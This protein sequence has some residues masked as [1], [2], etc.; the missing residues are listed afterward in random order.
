MN[1]HDLVHELLANCLLTQ[2]IIYF[3]LPNTFVSYSRSVMSE[4]Q[5]FFAKYCTYVRIYLCKTREDGGVL[6]I[7]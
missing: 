4:V 6:Q 5:G 3:H 1:I 7:W 2:Y